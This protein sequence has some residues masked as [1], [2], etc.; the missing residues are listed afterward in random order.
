VSSV[1]GKPGIGL[2]WPLAREVSGLRKRRAYQPNCPRS[3]SGVALLA[4]SW[5]TG[6]NLL[7]GH[8]MFPVQ[9]V[10]RPHAD[11]SRSSHVW[12]EST[13]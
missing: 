5:R 9:V 7:S 1:N 13:S 8:A 2:A 4:G 12:I 3:R 6:R 11:L 10:E